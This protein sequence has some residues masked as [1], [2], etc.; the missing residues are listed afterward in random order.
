M[1]VKIL[2]DISSEG[3]KNKVLFALKGEELLVNCER[4]GKYIIKGNKQ[5]FPVSKDDDRISIIGQ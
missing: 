1:K 3:Q 4:D 2:K 5:V